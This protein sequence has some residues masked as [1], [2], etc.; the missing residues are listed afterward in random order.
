ML[1]KYLSFL[2]CPVTRS[3]LRLHTISVKTK[4]FSSGE[5]EII[6]EG[7]LFA[8]KDWFYPIID[9]VPRLLIESFL[10]YEEFFKEKL[11][12]YEAHKDHLLKNYSGLIQQV[13]KK[14]RKTKKS[15]EFEW[16]LFNY[17]EDKTWELK[18]G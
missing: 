14:N 18:G 1:E 12:D 4:M 10:D 11:P 7:V 16:G 17:E 9:G 8:D 15:F 2:V 6:N 5:Q 13:V 3:S